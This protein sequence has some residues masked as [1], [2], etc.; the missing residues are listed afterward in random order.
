[1][2]TFAALSFSNIH[3]QKMWYQM[4]KSSMI[5]K[6]F[7]TKIPKLQNFD[8]IGAKNFRFYALSILYFDIL[9]SDV[10]ME[11]QFLSQAA[12]YLITTLLL[13]NYVIISKFMLLSPS[14]FICKKMIISTLISPGDGW[15]RTRW[16]IKK[17]MEST[18]PKNTSKIYLHVKQFSLKTDLRLVEK[19]LLKNKTH[20]QK[21]KQY[22]C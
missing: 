9:I 5:S 6:D 14:V 2:Q 17:D 8:S 11:N 12:L 22:S 18:C 16:W 19:L 21:H 20:N 7:L 4:A 3:L 10:G 1:M 13:T 15:W